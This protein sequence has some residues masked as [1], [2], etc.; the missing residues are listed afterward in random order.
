[1]KTK[2][3][4]M[5]AKEAHNEMYRVVTPS[6]ISE[7][8]YLMVFMTVNRILFEQAIAGK[9]LPDTPLL[10]ECSLNNDTDSTLHQV[11]NIMI[12]TG[13]TIFNAE[14]KNK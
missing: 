5:T 10:I 9:I 13:E 6:D 2:V 11:E 12:L 3:F 4:K 7:H 1:M 14:D 8:N